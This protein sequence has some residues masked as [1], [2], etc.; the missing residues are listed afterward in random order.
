MGRA[1]LTPKYHRQI[2]GRKLS[3]CWRQG[4]DLDY[5]LPNKHIGVA[6]LVLLLRVT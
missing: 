2:D 3:Q 4:G 1:V 6:A 5:G